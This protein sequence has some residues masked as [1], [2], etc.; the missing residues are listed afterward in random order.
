MCLLT[1]GIAN[2]F[3]SVVYACQDMTV[4]ANSPCV[5]EIKICT[6][7]VP[8]NATKQGEV[9]AAGNF[10]CD[11]PSSGM[12]CVGTGSFALCR[13]VYACMS[14]GTNCVINTSNAQS[15]VAETKMGKNCA[16]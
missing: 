16:S 13:T 1:I 3:V 2:H 10:Q 4:R 8:C 5:T 14:V 6:G 7:A 15:Y 12:A 11:S 9:A